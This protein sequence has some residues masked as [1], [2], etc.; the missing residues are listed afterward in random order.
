MDIVQCPRNIHL[1]LVDDVV[2]VYTR[3]EM[4]LNIW[5]LAVLRNS[6]MEPMINLKEFKPTCQST[7]EKLFKI[8]TSLTGNF[9]E[10]IQLFGQQ[11]FR[12][13]LFHKKERTKSRR[14]SKK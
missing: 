1:L 3:E 8:P 7:L 4:Q 12:D 9:P 5:Y 14:P 10:K 11:I 13:I 2:E 6:T